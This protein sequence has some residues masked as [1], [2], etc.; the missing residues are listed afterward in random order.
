MSPS[1]VHIQDIGNISSHAHLPSHKRIEA[2]VE[3]N[4]IQIVDIIRFSRL[5]RHS[6]CVK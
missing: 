3:V 4:D 1:Y 2:S 5:L 6:A